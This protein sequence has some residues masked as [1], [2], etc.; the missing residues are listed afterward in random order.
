[1]KDSVNKIF[2]IADVTINGKREWDIKINSD[3]FYHKVLATGSLGMGESYMDGDW[4][5]VKLDVLFYKVLKSNLDKKA[6]RNLNLAL[7]SLLAKVM[8]QQSKIKSKRVAEQH[9]NLGNDLYE[10]MLDK[11]MQYTCAY[12]KNADNLEQ[13]QVNKL[14]LV[15]KKLKLSPGMK[16][17]ELGGGF[18]GLARYFAKHYKVKVHSYNISSEQVKY[19]RKICKDLDVVFHEKDYR[20]ATGHFDRVVSVG[21]M[22]HVGVKNYRSMMELIDKCLHPGGLA[23]VHTIGRN[24]SIFSG[25]GDPWIDKYIFPGGH[26]PSIAQITAASEGLLIVEDVHNIGPDYDRTLMAW[27]DNVNKHWGKLKH[28]YEKMMDGKF[29][30]MWDYYLL[31]CA[32]A[33]RARD[34]QLW[35]T[36][37][38]KGYEQKYEAV[39]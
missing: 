22:E 36:V 8:N 17:L 23:L 20:E 6:P 2:A 11:N 15:A 30:R 25:G 31:C 10:S 19:G 13:A 26:L 28:T 34:I 32:G 4:D 38:S 12:W 7:R 35:Q 1:M 39:R 18:G 9:Y 27:Y 33:F 16:V 37:F 24:T 5:A 3:R 21:M 14:E 29:K